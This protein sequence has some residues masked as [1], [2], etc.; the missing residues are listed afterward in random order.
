VAAYQMVLL[1]ETA[2]SHRHLPNARG[3]A[4]ALSVCRYARAAGIAAEV[5]PGERRI[6]LGLPCIDTVALEVARLEADAAL[7]SA[8][9]TANCLFGVI[10]GEGRSFIEGAE[11]R[12][13]RGDVFVEPSWRRHEYRAGKTSYLLKVTDEPFIRRLNWLRE[14]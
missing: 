1:G 11:F 3:V 6:E 7:S 10:E 5:A 12:W 13:S 8:R 4:H 2:R 9:T 14:E